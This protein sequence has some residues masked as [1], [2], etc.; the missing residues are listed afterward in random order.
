MATTTLGNANI[1]PWTPMGMRDAQQVSHVPC[2][3]VS[4]PFRKAIMAKKRGQ[5]KASEEKATGRSKNLPE[6]SK[7][8]AGGIGGAVLGGIVAGPVGAVVGGVAGAL[9]GNASAE[10][11][12]PIKKAAAS[13]RE[14]LRKRQPAVKKIAGP[15]TA[16]KA[17]KK[18]TQRSA[19]LKKT[20]KKKA[21]TASNAKSKPP[22]K[23]GAVKK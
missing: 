11:E 7:Q 16:K 12:Q 14:S 6:V 13:V 22:R 2:N 19:A 18:S 15:K 17:A 20:A 4:A 8:T 21:Q 23:K 9:V 1:V 5:L 10:G 3:N